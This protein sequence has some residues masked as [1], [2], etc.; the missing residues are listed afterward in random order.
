MSGKSFLIAGALTLASVGAA[1]AKSYEITLVS[2]AK[3]GSSQLKAGQY[4]LKVEGS[5]A[6][7]V[8]EQDASSVTVPVKIEH[9]GQ[10]FDQSAVETQNKDGVDIVREIMLGGTDTKVELGE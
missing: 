6:V 4:K 5:Q 8:S 9:N 3:A 10:K 2:P 1:S 7:F